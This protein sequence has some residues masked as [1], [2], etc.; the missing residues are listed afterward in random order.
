M[1]SCENVLNELVAFLNSR[2]NGKQV[3]MSN[4]LKEHLA[5]C[6]DCK[7]LVDNPSEARSFLKFR[8]SMIALAEKASRNVKTDQI[9]PWQIC[10]FYYDDNN[11]V[12][13]GLVRNAFFAGKNDEFGTVYVTPLIPNYNKLEVTEK[14]ITIN[15]D[16]SPMGLP[17]LIEAW[18]GIKE[19]DISQVE[20]WYGSISNNYRSFV[21]NY[22]TEN[23]S[24]LNETV[25]VFRAFEKKRASYFSETKNTMNHTISRRETVINYQQ[26]DNRI[27][28]AASSTKDFDDLEQ[29]YD[30]NIKP[31][32]KE[33]KDFSVDL[34]DDYIL[35]CNDNKNDFLITFKDSF[36]ATVAFESI[37]G[38]LRLTLEKITA[39]DSYNFSVERINK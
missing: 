32:F 20:T 2:V 19:L 30:K 17:L 10:K 37:D 16:E 33:I 34:M 31:C 24:N 36:G 11:E 15:A 18:N 26:D 8:E 12:A 21:N 3:S 22:E 1:I 27:R 4:E 25:K 28:L 13:F 38:K 23:E 6:E 9:T 7:A 29:I 39:L 14:D 35:I 5:T